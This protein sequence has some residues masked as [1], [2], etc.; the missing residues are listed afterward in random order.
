MDLGLSGLVSGLDWRTLVDK[1]ADVERV[2]AN[3]LRAEQTTLQQQNT[4]Y[5]TL[6]TQLS[7][8][9]SRITL[10][11]DPTLFDSRQSVTSDAAI[12]SAVAGGGAA[13]G[14]YNFNFIQ[15]ATA[16][17]QMGAPGAGSSLNATN[18][19]SALVL[20]EAAFASRITGGTFTVNGR[21]LTIATADTLQEVFDKISVATAGSVT[22]SYDA[23][24]DRITLSS[25]GPIVLGSATDSSNFLQVAHLHN[26]GTGTISSAAELGVIRQSASLTTANFATAISD[27]GAGA[28]EFRINGVTIT[29]AETDSVA[30]VLKRINDSTAGVAA[31]Y[32]AVSDRFVLTNKTTGD[33]GIALEDVTG[34][35]LA[36]AGL[37]GGTLERG[38]NLRYTVNGGSE[39]ISQSNTITE[40]S[41]GVAGL[42]VTATATGTATVT[43]S[44]DTAKI[45]QAITDF[46]TEYNKVQSVID[47]QTASTTDAKGKVT[48]GLL[49][50]DSEASGIA[51]Q[52]RR[53]VTNQVLGMDS[54]LKRLDDLGIVSNGNDNTLKLDDE[55]KL[56]AALA[57]KLTTVRLLFA[58]SAQGLAVKL[59]GYL[60]KLVGDDGALPGKQDK[61]TR[62]ASAI[63]TQIADL[64]RLVQAN[65]E[66]MIASF[67]AMETAQSQINQQLQF[68]QQRFGSNSSK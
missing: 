32:D 14:A 38:Q 64:E 46:L 8:L 40:A 29:F 6:K 2:P 65:R 50:S 27:G 58:D 54:L 20:S 30:A 21:Q 3:R 63:D 7:A 49:A 42:S 16:A 45:K 67:I 61:L 33:M 15:L 28:G 4:A 24:T 13:L 12:A 41:S 18:D 57:D 62:A 44:S 53:L 34:N 60:E 35:F 26:N 5:T 9:Q 55:A 10:L 48:A 25:A 39:V 22:G 31:N 52:L 59:N 11:Q 51:S 43:V 17:R 56:D 19:V 66:R 23:A 1:L 47:S 36:A 37:T 68:L